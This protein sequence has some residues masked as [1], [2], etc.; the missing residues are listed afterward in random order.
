MARP[1]DPQHLA[2]FRL[3]PFQ[4]ATGA[5]ELFERLGK[6]SR[7][8]K[9]GAHAVEHRFGNHRRRF[10]RNL[11]VSPMAPPD[12]D[13]CLGQPIFRQ[14]VIGLIERGRL[15][16][17][18]GILPKRV[19]NRT[20]HAVWINLRDA[21]V[22]LFVTVFVPD[23]H[24]KKLGGSHKVESFKGWLRR[25]KIGQSWLSRDN[26]KN[27]SD[28]TDGIAHVAAGRRTARLELISEEGTQ[29]LAGR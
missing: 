16:V 8:Q 25:C 3:A 14:T 28:H 5:H 11:F 29:E 21:W 7:V 17:Q 23:Q 1:R 26:W 15:D 2:V 20:V 10:V 9:D 24:A 18:A 22:R 27:A 6:V 4:V 13:V 19:G 12:N